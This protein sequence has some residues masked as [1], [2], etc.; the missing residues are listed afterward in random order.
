M[1]TGD[2]SQSTTAD[3]NVP[4]FLN[5]SFLQRILDEHLKDENQHPVRI[6]RINVQ[7]ATKPGDNYSSD[8]FSVVVHYN[9]TQE[10]HFVVKVVLAGAIMKNF[11]DTIGAFVKEVNT[12]ERLLPAFSRIVSGTDNAAIKFGAN[13]FYA[14]RDPMD[15][16]VFEDLKALGYRMADRTR[17]GLDLAH[18]EL[19]MRKIGL[20]HAASMVYVAAAESTERQLFLE[21]YRHGM[22]QPG[23]DERTNPGLAMFKKG[24]EKFLE[25]AKHW[26]ELKRSIWLKLEALQSDYSRR[27]ARSVSPPGPDEQVA[28]RVLNHGDLWG[29]NMMF[30]Y[31]DP[32]DDASVR[33]VTFVDYQLS[34]Y[35]SAGH[36]LVY[37]LYN[38]PQFEVRETRINDL[39]EVYHRSL[40]EGLRA[41]DYQRQP[42]PSFA[43]V[44]KEYERHEF[45]GVVSGLSMLP[46]ILMEHTDDVKL[47]FENLIDAEHA[48]KIRDIQYNG[49]LYRKSV[50]P[51]L[52]RLDAK[53]LLD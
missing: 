32:A 10:I 11:C 18:C 26:P 48:E 9:D 45:I 41:G 15:T 7:L 16:I 2:S 8:V 25:V 30:R 23:D 34:S 1:S 12:F 51:I 49:Q 39:L 44:Q 29:N 3:I 46:I 13:C 53:G 19:I 36:D 4:G 38:C 24:L 47:T 35:G 43:D 6:D 50:V 14:T 40:C 21:R 42:L 20:F 27:V 31:D 28:Y 33:E 17:G 52:E 37:S 22:A 5:E